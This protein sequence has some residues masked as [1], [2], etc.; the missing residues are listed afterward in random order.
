LIIFLL[1]VGTTAKARKGTA[2]RI[3]KTALRKID[4][5]WVSEKVESG[6]A[7]GEA[8]VDAIC[9]ANPKF[10]VPGVDDKRLLQMESE[11]SRLL[12]LMERGGGPI[13]AETLQLAY[14]GN[15]ELSNRAKTAP[16]KAK[17]SPGRPTVL[18]SLQPI[19]MLG[20]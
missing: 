16:R 17:A 15:E 6:L 12:A 18:R 2:W 5:Q 7:T 14:D 4:P 9:D 3:V 20:F 13:F 19:H 8:L 1:L 10:N 11:V